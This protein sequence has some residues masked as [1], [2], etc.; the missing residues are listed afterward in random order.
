MHTNFKERKVP[1][2]ASG[3]QWFCLRMVVLSDACSAQYLFHDLR[4]KFL[5]NA[6]EVARS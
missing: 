1:L 3:S 2:A 4:Q 5:K 6:L